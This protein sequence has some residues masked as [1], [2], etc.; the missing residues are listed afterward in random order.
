MIRHVFKR[1]YFTVHES[2]LE[3]SYAFRDG[4]SESQFAEVLEKEVTAFKRVGQFKLLF[5]FKDT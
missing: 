1:S 2:K 3:H 4:V 5:S